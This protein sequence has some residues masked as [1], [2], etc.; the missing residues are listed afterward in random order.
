M[1]PPLPEPTG[2]I[3]YPLCDEPAYTAFQMTLYAGHAIE[4]FLRRTG[5]YLTNDAS[6]EAAIRAAVDAALRSGR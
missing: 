1:L 4:D 6:R 2:T 3:R 5:Q